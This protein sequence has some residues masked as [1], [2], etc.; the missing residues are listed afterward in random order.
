LSHVLLSNNQESAT[1]LALLNRVGGQSDIQWVFGEVAQ[2]LLNQVQ[3][4]ARV[5]LAGRDDSSWVLS[6]GETKAEQVDDNPPP[7]PRVLVQR[8]KDSG[9]AILCSDLNSGS[10]DKSMVRLIA[11]TALAVPLGGLRDTH[12]ALVLLGEGSAFSEKDLELAVALAFQVSGCFESLRTI[13]KLRAV[14]RRLRDENRY[15]REQSPSDSTFS[16]II[17]DSEAIRRVFEY[18]KVVMNTDATVLVTGETGTGKEL[19]ARALHS[20]SGRAS[21]LFAAVNCA[22]LSENLLE[23]EL[24]GHVKGAFTGAHENKKGLFQ[25]ADKGSLFLD[26]IGELSGNLQ[27]KLLRVLQ[28]GEVTPVGSSRPLKVDVRIIAATHRDLRAEVKEGTFREDLFYR[29]NVFPI[30]IPP[31]RDRP[32]DIPL[33]AQ[34]FLDRY[35]K[36]FG[37]SVAGISERAIAALKSYS[38]PGNIRELENE[39]Q[40]ALLLASTGENICVR[41]LS[42]HVS[43]GSPLSAQPVAAPSGKLK[44]TMAQLERQVLLVALE[45]NGWNR[46][47]TARQLGIS[48]QALMVKLSKYELAPD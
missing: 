33:L 38:F 16:D 24:F 45:G 6:R 36:K 8:A 17:G 44:E 20:N 7:Y 42:D 39:I 30:H 5:V 34:Y 1:L 43:G 2:Y 47:E 28:E 21:R 22:A 9:E 46:S 15:L 3:S 18:L 48:R 10:G 14:E 25:V 27:A 26:E 23:S 31:L 4:A 35:S 37:K 29:I 12:G 40:R 11:Q 41:E 13:Q 19:I 32:T